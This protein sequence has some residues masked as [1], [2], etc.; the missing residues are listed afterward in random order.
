MSVL[1]PCALSS[2]CLVSCWSMVFGSRHSFVEFWFVSGFGHSKKK[3]K[4]NPVGEN[5]TAD[6]AWQGRAGQGRAGLSRAEQGRA[7]QGRAGQGRAGQGRA[8]L[9]RAEQGRAGQGRAG[10]GRA[11]QGRAGQGRTCQALPAVLFSPTGSFFF[12]FYIKPIS[13]TIESSPHPFILSLDT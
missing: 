10:Q 12:I 3:K 11:G 8:G 2:A 4:K 13:C 5:R 7:G 6:K 9:S 1:E